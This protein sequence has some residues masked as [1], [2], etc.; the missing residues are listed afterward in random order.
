MG[1]VLISHCFASV[2]GVVFIS[3]I[4]GRPRT[5]VSLHSLDICLGKNNVLYSEPSLML[6][7]MYTFQASNTFQANQRINITTVSH[8]YV[9]TL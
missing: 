8:W 4:T 5:F 9:L 7:E 2:M 6:A 1:I 3:L